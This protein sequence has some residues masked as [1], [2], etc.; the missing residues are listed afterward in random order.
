[1]KA[2]AYGE[3]APHHCS[4]S[5]CSR[6]SQL[7]EDL[8]RMDATRQVFP[9]LLEECAQTAFLDNVEAS[10][11]IEGLYPLAGRT[12]LLLN[13]IAQAESDLDHQILG[14]A[15]AQRNLL[16]HATVLPVSTT[17]ILAIYGDMFSYRGQNKKSSYRKRDY[18]DMLI[19]GHPQRVQVS[20]VEAFETPLYL[21]SA[22]DALSAALGT[23]RE[24]SALECD[25]VLPIAQFAVDFMCIHPFEEGNG[26]IVRLFSDF[27]AVR[28]GI[29]IARY[30]SVNRIIEAD[31]MAYYEA[32][33]AC[34]R[35]W[36]TG[37]NTY[38]PFIE[39][40]LDVLHRAYSQ[41]F[42]L[43]EMTDG[44]APKKPERI[45]AFFNNHAGQHSKSD[46]AQAHPDISIST[47]ENAL[48]DLV[49]EGFLHKTG[50]G[51]STRYERNPE[52]GLHTNA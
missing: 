49:S 1:M 37:T 39:Y 22:C 5:C 17:T 16:E 3:A 29:D 32:L 51:R 15:T 23:P 28:S 24:G 43:T 47:I 19:D 25:A 6:M 46:V 31:G 44:G 30:M 8:G 26:R 21:G 18:M 52:A 14:L 10:T 20:P 27:L 38:A 4:K 50:A 34:T 40:W 13:G 41:L 9:A 35:G 45:R 2:F 33:N 42:A 7:S 11:H 12:A 48:R 36:D